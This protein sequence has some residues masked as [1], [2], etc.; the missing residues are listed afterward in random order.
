MMTEVHH[1]LEYKARGEERCEQ[2]PA[3]FV[4]RRGEYAHEKVVAFSCK[5]RGFCPSC[6]VW[7]MEETAL[8]L[9]P[10]AFE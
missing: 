5:G 3:R 9:V 8:H 2:R 10:T 7:R 6:T 4:L 1:P